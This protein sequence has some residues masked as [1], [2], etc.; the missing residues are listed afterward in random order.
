M[1]ENQNGLALVSS[2]LVDG[3]LSHLL[4][5]AQ[6]IHFLTNEILEMVKFE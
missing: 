5:L 2:A 6:I 4:V 1:V 3:K